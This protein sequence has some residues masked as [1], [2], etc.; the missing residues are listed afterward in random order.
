VD[1]CVTNAFVY[2]EV[3]SKKASQEELRHGCRTVLRRATINSS[4]GKSMI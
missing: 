1:Y 2:D 4:A 3:S